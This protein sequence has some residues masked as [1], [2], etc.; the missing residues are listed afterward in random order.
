V[1]Q[2]LEFNQQLVRLAS[3]WWLV[4]ICYEKKILL[5]DRWLVLI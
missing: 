4:L 3:G 1:V 2:N 5:A